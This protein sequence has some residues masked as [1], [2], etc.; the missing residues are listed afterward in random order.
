LLT[1]LGRYADKTIELGWLFVAVFTPLFFNVY[2]AR[3]FEPDKISTLRSLVLIMTLAWIIKLL[4]GGVSAYSKSSATTAGGKV[5]DVTRGMAERGL[6]SWLGFLRVPM[7]IPILVYAL[8]YLI[9]T[10]FS[11]TVETSI[12]GSYQRLQGT[13]A[14][15]SYMMLGILIIANLRTRAQADRLV[16]FLI[17]TSVP[18]VLYGI[19]QAAPLINAKWTVDPLPWAGDT[20]TRV[21]STMGNA[22]FVAAWLIMLVPLTLYKLFNG[23]STSVAAGHAEDDILKSGERTRALSSRRMAADRPS[24]GWA[25]AANTLGILMIQ[26]FA[27]MLSLRLMKGLPFP[28]ASW[29]WVLPSAIL[30]FYLGCHLIEWLANRRDDPR[31]ASLFMPIVGVTLLVVATLA[32]CVTWSVVQTQQQQNGPVMLA[33]AAA[34][35]GGAFLW[36]LFFTLL[37]ASAS[38][39]AYTLAAD[40]RTTSAGMGSPIVRK[41]LNIGYGLLVVMQILCIYLTQSRG[42][43]LGLGVGLA[44]FF[45]AMW[46]VGRT[47][48]VRWMAR[49]GGTVSAIVLALVLF[50]GV[51]NIP[52]SPLKALDQMPIFGR[53]IERLSTLFRTEDGTGKV[54][55]LI[56]KGATDLIVSDPTRALIGRGPESMY[57]AYNPF[58][59]PELARWELRNATP[60]RSHNAEFDQM[61]T[62]GV[63]GLFAYYFLVAAFFIYGIRVLKRLTDT[64]D[65]LLLI[66]LL[67]VM[68][69]HFIEIQ[70]GI[71]IAATWTYFY[72]TIG[73]MVAFG[74]YVTPH[75][76]ERVSSTVEAVPTIEHAKGN[77]AVRGEA[78]A[79]VP[80]ATSIASARPSAVATPQKGA[81]A[82]MSL[83]SSSSNKGQPAPQTS[84]GK[85]PSRP[86]P[87]IPQQTRASGHNTDGKRKQSP[88]QQVAGTR[89]KSQSPRNAVPDE[90][91]Y[92]DPGRL[93]LYAGLAIVVYIFNFGLNLTGLGVPIN[94]PG[95]NSAS[96]RADTL[97]KSG[98]NADEKKAWPESI[99]Y[100]RQAI[101]TQPNQDYY[102]LF[103][104]RAWL[105]FAKQAESEPENYRIRFQVPVDVPCGPATQKYDSEANTR[106]PN[107]DPSRVAER[108]CRLKQAERVLTNAH[109]INP[110]NSDHFANLGRMYS[111]WASTLSDDD[112]ERARLLKLAFD[113]SKIASERTPGNAQ[114][115]NELARAYVLTG[116]FSKGIEAIQVSA[117]LDPTYV[118]TPFLRSQFYQDRARTVRETL[119]N[120]KPLPTD[121]ETDYGK[122][123]MEVGKAY[124]DTIGLSLPKVVDAS[125]KSRV[126]YLLEVTKPFTATNTTLDEATVSNILTSTVRVALE[127]KVIEGEKALVSLLRDRKVYQG[128]S[129]VVS[130]EAL[131]ELWSNPEWA[132]LTMK[133]DKIESVAWRDAAYPATAVPLA[134]AYYA[135]GYIY[136]KTG[137]PERAVQS[138]TRATSL[139]PNNQDALK[140]L[141]ALNGTQP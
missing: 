79:K 131:Q 89:P 100:Y 118:E 132:T 19:I 137:L 45:L 61:V 66:A 37:W 80:V 92:S 24:F 86:A 17:L 122:L 55:E 23:V 94:V 31:Q 140:A 33:P 10:I 2:S 110:L 3:V 96:V 57:V 105:E 112:P 107:S 9:S 29:A 72:L 104:G 93:A 59:P 14:Q 127:N 117:Q 82:T 109:E 69:A 76:R 46:L 67:S 44:V 58:Y 98:T 48:D 50:I 123:L 13:Y 60:D 113:N 84:N 116:Q 136:E 38:A 52:G 28:D 95:V 75:L 43:W 124:S 5:A 1:R 90:R 18:V 53:G 70:T 36:V 26:M 56:W 42:P 77:G 128:E 20:A 40:E 97:Y 30:S 119:T 47:Q 21:A 88:S 35:D 7:V 87:A 134:L 85:G 32:I 141:Q 71:Q 63:L 101:A 74:Y 133:G 54:R 27:F 78:E 62:M 4:E 125:F 25:L 111:Y 99:S 126:D 6:P 22:I 8:A 129:D 11:I 64:R 51:L 91:W 65:Q 41:A 106:G 102:Y 12:F 83:G 114:L 135:T 138:Y 139:D 73:L 16:N 81:M 15:Y 130:N 34:F 49:F 115:R 103:L 108:V 68:S 39:G 120:K 121:G